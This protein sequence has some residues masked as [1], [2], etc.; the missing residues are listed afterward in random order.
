MWPNQSP[1]QAVNLEEE[2]NDSMTS[3]CPTDDGICTSGSE[4]RPGDGESIWLESLWLQGYKFP[5]KETYTH[6]SQF[7][8]FHFFLIFDICPEQVC[9]V[10]PWVSRALT[11]WVPSDR[12]PPTQ[13]SPTTPS[14]PTTQSC[15]STQ[16]C[17]PF[18]GDR[19]WSTQ[20]SQWPCLSVTLVHKVVIFDNKQFHWF[21]STSSFNSPDST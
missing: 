2:E 21:Q 7:G 6:F 12:F 16:G 5:T 11:T 4:G 1:Q 18:Q 9:E 17:R 13:S 3:Y 20:G 15:W 8:N 19:C 10:L 14:S